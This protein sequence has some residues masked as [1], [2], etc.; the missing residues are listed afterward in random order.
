MPTIDAM[1]DDEVERVDGCEESY[2]FPVSAV[3]A[4]DTPPHMDAAPGVGRR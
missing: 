4:A 2:W 3:Y 1:T